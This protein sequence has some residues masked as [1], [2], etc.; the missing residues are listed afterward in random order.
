MRALAS[1]CRAL[2]LG[3][4]PLLSCAQTFAAADVPLQHF[5]GVWINTRPLQ[6][7]RPIEGGAVPLTAEGRARYEAIRA[8]RKSGQ[9]IDEARHVCLPEGMPRA[10]SSPYPMQIMVTPG[11]VTFFHEA[12]RAY[13]M[14]HLDRPHA[15]PG[16]WDPTYMGE[17]TGRY[18]AGVLVIDSINYKDERV[19]LDESGLPVSAA[20]HLTEQLRLLDNGRTLE[21]VVTIDD[22]LN[23]SRSWQ[24]RFLFSRRDDVQVRTDWV[25]GEVHRSLQSLHKASKPPTPALTEQTGR[26]LTAEQSAL[27]GYWRGD[28]RPLPGVAH[29]AAGPV[30]TDGP[31]LGPG[32]IPSVILT[33]ALPR[34]QPWAA[35]FRRRFLAAEAQGQQQRTPGN[36][37]LPYAIPGTGVPGGPAYSLQLLIEP[38]QVTFLYQ[39]NR[40]IRIARIGGQHPPK[41]APSWL[42]D[43]IAHWE[44]N[45]LVVDTVGFNDTNLIGDT[46]PFTRAMHIVQRLTVEDGKLV[47]RAV[48]TDPGTFDHAFEA[49]HRFEAAEPF[50]EYLCAED[51]REGGVPTASGK[52]TPYRLPGATTTAEGL[53]TR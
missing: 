2:L 29:I 33:A 6:Q 42:G 38:R 40:Q 35:D 8:G 19:F 48:F 39:E 28:R 52:P 18:S 53:R 44:G 36:L 4:I 25:C 45:T 22:P 31:P 13:R 7:V 51:N 15:D 9:S 24:L 21:D 23:Y 37:C 49:V 30:T 20:L 34:L 41:L 16:V 1:L 46:V 12:N 26:A 43:S 14:V 11:Q 50:Q 10:L 47:D 27:N 5:S 17:G 32:G 3:L